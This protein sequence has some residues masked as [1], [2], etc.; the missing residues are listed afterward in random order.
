MILE[1]ADILWPGQST[2]A[3]DSTAFSGLP[4]TGKLETTRLYQSA[5]VKEQEP[6]GQPFSAR[7][8]LLLLPLI[9][10]AIF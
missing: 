2:V 1:A 7:N 3:A 8:R 5:R 4:V 6:A 10:S 9:E